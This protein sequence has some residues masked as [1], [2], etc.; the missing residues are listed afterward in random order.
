[1]SFGVQGIEGTYTIVAQSQSN[2]SCDAVMEGA[3][4]LELQT[5]FTLNPSENIVRELKSH[6]TDRNHG[7]NMCFTAIIALTED[8]IIGTGAILSFGPRYIAGKYTIKSYNELWECNAPMAD[9]CIILSAPVPYAVIPQGIHCV[10][11][12]III[13]LEDSD[14]G[15]DLQVVHGK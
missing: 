1:M 8:T 7:F 2:P 5:V 11:E 15:G 13:G 6:S 9:T 4:I 3:P 14:P 10:D 12:S